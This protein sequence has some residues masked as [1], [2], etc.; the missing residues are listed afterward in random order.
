MNSNPNNNQNNKP[1]TYT[2]IKK[3]GEGSFGKAYLVECTADK[4]K[5]SLNKGSMRHKNDKYR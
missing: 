2:Q 5:V 4:V 1:Q 3:L